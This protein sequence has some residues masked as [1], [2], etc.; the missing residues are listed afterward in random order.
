ML[1]REM[2]QAVCAFCPVWTLQADRCVK[3]FVSV[4]VE[5][6]ADDAFFDVF[7]EKDF[8]VQ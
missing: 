6:L 3:V 1:K 8:D 5:F 7:S 2:I 4:H